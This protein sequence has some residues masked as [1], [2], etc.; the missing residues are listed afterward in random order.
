MKPKDP[1]LVVKCAK[2]LFTLPF[3]VRDSKLGIIYLKKA[4]KMAP[5]D[6]TVLHAVK[7][8]FE[9]YKT[10]VKLYVSKYILMF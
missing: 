8:A 3:L 4:I 1:L 10:I 2:M 9:A 5:T 7:I 6:P